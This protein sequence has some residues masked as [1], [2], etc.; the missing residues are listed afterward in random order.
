MV[1]K[2][3]FLESRTRSRSQHGMEQGTPSHSQGPLSIL[4]VHGTRK[5]VPYRVR[6]ISIPYSKDG[7]S[8]GFLRCKLVPF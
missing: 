8:H 1:L 2:S 7:N 6:N 5:Y 3:Y 4:C